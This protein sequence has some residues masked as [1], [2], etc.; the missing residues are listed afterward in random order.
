MKRGK[1]GFLTIA[2]FAAAGTL[3]AFSVVGSSRAALTYFS[4]TYGA[5]VSMLDIGITL[6]ENGEAVVTGG[7]GN[8]VRGAVQGQLLSGLG[9]EEEESPRPG[10][11]Y[12][13]DLAV[14]NTGSIDEY[15]R[16]TL[17][18]YWEKKNP[19]TG[20]YEKAPELDSS[21]IEVHFANS[22]LWRADESSATEERTVLYYTQ[23]LAVGAVSPAF[24]DTVEI[25]DEGVEAAVTETQSTDGAGNTVLTTVYDYDEAR[26][27]LRA[28]VEAVQSHNADD[29]MMSAW[30]TTG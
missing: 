1:S 29:A 24:A 21:L 14:K 22:G 12:P 18:R 8:D 17:Y 27:V 16:V 13:V 6:L 3:L 10:M 25:S 5:E 28:D 26:F 23:P 9:A 2:L 30:G 11:K 7:A 19:L 15:V 4:E 20:A